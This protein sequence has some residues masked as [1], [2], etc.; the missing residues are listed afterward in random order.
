MGRRRLPLPAAVKVLARRL[1][2][3]RQSPDRQRR[4]PESMWAQAAAL[5]QQHGIGR[6]QAALRLNYADL[7]RRVQPDRPARLAASS[8][9]PFVELGLTGLVPPQGSGTTIELQDQ[10]GRRLLVRLGAGQAGDWTV[11]AR[12]LWSAG[13]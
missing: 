5:A 13:R 10:T 2:V 4:L 6:V 9:P 7:K 3:Y 1:E 8:A 11:V 12:A